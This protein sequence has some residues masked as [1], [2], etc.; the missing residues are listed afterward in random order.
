MY[1]SGY[2]IEVEWDIFTIMVI[3]AIIPKPLL[4]AFTTLSCVCR[5]PF[6]CVLIFV[7]G[8]MNIHALV[9]ILISGLTMLF[10][11]NSFDIAGVCHKNN[12]K[13]ES[14]I[15]IVH[16]YF[17]LL[18]YIFYNWGNFLNYLFFMRVGCVFLSLLLLYLIFVKLYM[19]LFLVQSISAL[20]FLFICL[21]IYIFFR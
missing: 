16:Q 15:F 9:V 20:F 7:I 14:K 6:C 4:T 11:Y 5:P 17:T 21:Y 10:F 13:Y 19:M 18:T 8:K 3:L 12:N 2:S 1:I